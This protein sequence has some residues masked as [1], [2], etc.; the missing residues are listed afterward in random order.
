MSLN[1]LVGMFHFFS[2]ILIEQFWAIEKYKSHKMQIT[3]LSYLK[4]IVIDCAS[5]GTS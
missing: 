4:I 3:F 2:D 5:L 1:K